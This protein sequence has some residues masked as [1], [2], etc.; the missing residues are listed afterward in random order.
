MTATLDRP[1]ET[2]EK[3]INPLPSTLAGKVPTLA[4]SAAAHL[5]PEQVERLG[6]ELDALRAEV[7]AT[8]GEKDAEY[9][10]R[11]VRLQ[12]G[13]EVGGR[14]ALLFSLFP[15]AWL[16]GTAALS[17]SKILDNMELGHNI[18]HGQWDWMRD[19]K[20]HSTTW[21]WDHSSPAEFWQKSHN[22]EHH[23]FT[24]VRG[25][26]RDL[27]YA[28]MR[29][30]PEQEWRPADLLQPLTNVLL[31]LF[32]EYAITIYD[33]E[34]EKLQEGT[35]TKAEVAAQLRTIWRKGRK[36]WAKDFVLFPLLSGPGFL[37]TL[38][39]NVTAG[40]VRNIWSHA[41]IFCGH[42]PDGTETFE[43]DRLEG[44]TK[45]E[46][47]VR[48][49]LGSANLTGSPAFHVMT[50]NLSHQIEHHL[51]PDMPS[52]RYGTIAPRVREICERY[53]LPYTAGSLP[54]QYAK[55]VRK[56]FRLALPGGGPKKR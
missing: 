7:M 14:A 20:I 30:T 18:L 17:V 11:L 16:A 56:I 48:Q 2:T 28:V 53:G 25:R 54:R 27:G 46:W 4:P 10:Q 32:F 34:L 22:Y 36:Q 45:G 42:F 40:T 8:L 3:P 13:L 23:T 47:Y 51:F 55:V 31:S 38:A 52:N 19:P 37:T 1:V 6:E 35:K 29:I 5:T 21:E 9:I 33:L 43:E 44:E 50:G 41:V 26:D 49:L 15:P 39:A 12:R 24:N